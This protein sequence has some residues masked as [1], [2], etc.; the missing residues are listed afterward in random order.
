M[1]LLLQVAAVD[2]GSPQRESTARV[3]FMVEG[4]LT[5]SEH[6]PHFLETGRTEQVFEND[7][8]GRM[9]CLVSAEDADHD[10]LWYSITGTL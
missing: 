9:V 4:A 2:Q 1:Y 10:K 7:A 3:L 6:A 8:V 5:E